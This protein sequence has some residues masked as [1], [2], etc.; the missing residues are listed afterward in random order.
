M[1]LLLMAFFAIGLCFAPNFLIAQTISGKIS[2]QVADEN[3]RALEGATVALTRLRDSVTIKYELTLADGSF[4]FGISVVGTFCVKIASVGKMPFKSEGITVDSQHPLIVLKPVTMQTSAKILQ[5]VVI[6]SKKA[7]VEQKIDR[8]VVNVDALISNAGTTALEVLEKSPGVAIDQNGQISFHGKSGVAIYVDDKPTYLSGSDLENYLRSMPSSTLSQIEL[9]TNPPAKYDAA[10]TAG[11]INIKT[12]KTKVKGFNLGVN[13]GL[14]QSLYT[15]TNNSMDFNY[16]KDKVNVFGTFAYTFSNGFNDIDI[17]RSYFYNA[18]QPSGAFIQNSYIRTKSSGYNA[19]LGMD[20]YSSENTTIGVLFNGIIRSPDQ[21]N[22]SKGQLWNAAGLAD[23]SIVSK[24]KELG[25]FKNGSA[26]LNYQH[27]FKK[28]GPEIT[29]NLDYLAFETDN[30]Q[31]F[32]NQSQAVTGAVSTDQLNGNLPAAINIYSAKADYSQPLAGGWKL[33]SGVKSSYANTD[34][35]ANYFNIVKGTAITDNDKTNHFLYREAINA[36]YINLNKDFKR[37]SVQAG[38]RLENTDS[39]GHQL[40]NAPKPDSAFNRNYTGL[41][42]TLYLLY[43]L[44]TLG[45]HQLKMTYGRRIERPY[46]Q[47][48]NPF[49][50]P[51]DKYTFYTGNP[52]LLPSYSGNFELGYIYKD[53]ISVTMTYT[54][55]RDRSTETIEI[56]NGYYFSRPG[57]IGSTKLYDLNADASFDPANWFSLELS[58][59]V[60]QIRQASSFY[61]GT[62]NSRNTSFSGRA[63]MQFK[64]KKGWTLE[65]DGKYQSKQADAQFTLAAKGRLNIAASKTLSPHTTL[66]LSINDLLNTNINQGAINK[67]Y[68]TNASFRTLK[69]S[70]AALLTLSM[71]FGKSVKD[72]RKHDQTGAGEES[73]RVK[74]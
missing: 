14:R 16:R 21:F 10:E 58:G 39:R 53:R 27:T 37:L 68:Q 18:G 29:A 22:N 60:W 7:F 43:K 38:L 67:L 23:S 52:Y 20:L 30:K 73:D 48:L 35:L 11:I 36:G 46:Y 51:L 40:G 4:N 13:L 56:R 42:P 71:R 25:K 63:V 34:N 44:D 66:K 15:A 3:G 6:T 5:E 65:T 47:D 72:Q 70:R 9:M 26:N 28:D 49:I 12:K 45:D 55:I 74:E 64:L 17:N 50:S 8:T 57:N 61:T 69:D 54:D 1:K 2:G 33:E 62:L 41:F 19:K 24:N 32:L 31:T 59:D